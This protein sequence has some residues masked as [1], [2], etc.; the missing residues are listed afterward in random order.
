MRLP[1]ITRDMVLCAAGL[2]GIAHQA[3]VEHVD[4]PSLLMVYAGMIGLPAFLRLDE[5]RRNGK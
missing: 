1:K 2:L 4:R 5:R 3:L